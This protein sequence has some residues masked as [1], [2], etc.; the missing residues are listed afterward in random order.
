MGEVEGG[1]SGKPAL[2]SLNAA[3]LF[4]AGLLVCTPAAFCLAETAPESVPKMLDADDAAEKDAGRPAGAAD[5]AAGI[6]DSISRA[7]ASFEKEI[8]EIYYRELLKSPNIGG[9]IA[10][11]FT[12]R[13]GG[14]VADVKVDRSSL[15]WPPLEEGILNRIGTWK[16]SPFE[17]NPVSVTVPYKFGRS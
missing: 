12:V 6:R 2:R 9:E 17:G 4:V 13:P 3:A 15:N 11:S 5:N 10:V 14:D 16:F 8:R 7:I 1:I